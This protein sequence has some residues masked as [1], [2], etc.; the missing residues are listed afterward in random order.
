[1]VLQDD[2]IWNLAQRFT[3][4]SEIWTLGLKV[5]KFEEHQVASIW[6]KHKQDANLTA[7][8]LLQK[9]LQQFKIPTEAYMSLYDALTKNGMSQRARLLKQWVEGDRINQINLTPQ[10]TYQTSQ[11]IKHTF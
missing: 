6:N 8:D 9:W 4:E 10:S 11:V 7:R 3:D 1:M 2:H 5:L